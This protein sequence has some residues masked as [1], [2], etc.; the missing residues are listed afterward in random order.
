MGLTQFSVTAS[1][2]EYDILRSLFELVLLLSVSL[3]SSI[4]DHREDPKSRS[5]LGV[6]V[7]HP[8]VQ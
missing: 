6:P 2:L 4:P 8:S 5:L 7:K 3:K 1:L